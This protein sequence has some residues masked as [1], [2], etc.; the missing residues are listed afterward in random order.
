MQL[1]ISQPQILEPMNKIAKIRST[2]SVKINGKNMKNHIKA[3][4]HNETQ[5]E[6]EDSYKIMIKVMKPYIFQTPSCVLC[7][8]TC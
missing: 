5:E 3:Q 6:N 8:T 7:Y 2:Y 4:V 1:T